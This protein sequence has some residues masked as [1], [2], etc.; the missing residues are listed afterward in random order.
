GEREVRG[1]LAATWRSVNAAPKP[2]TV[3]G[4]LVPGT[5]KCASVVVLPS[6]AK[7]RG[8]LNV[9][10]VPGYVALMSPK[11]GDGAP[12]ISNPEPGVV[13]TPPRKVGAELN[14]AI[15]DEKVVAGAGA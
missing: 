5:K 12:L 9:V 10:K 8:A 7:S 3:A 6:G 1:G 15:G 2:V 14:V 4:P 13:K 11:R